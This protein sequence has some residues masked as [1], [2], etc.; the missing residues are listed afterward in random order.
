MTPD[1]YVDSDIILDLVIG[2]Q[3]F[4][5]EAKR[6]FAMAEYGKVKLHTT[7]VVFANIFY[8]LRKQYSAETIKTNLKILRQLIS[9]IPADESSVD[10]A[11]T[12]PFTDF[13]D[14]LQY[15]AALD[16]GMSAII[17]RNLS[18]FR[19]ATIPVMTAGEFLAQFNS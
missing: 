3:P 12:S 7:P 19:F 15:H 10:K 9:I 6:L 2:R 17:T 5:A 11:L 13:E 14:A 1:I 4:V 8:I 18:D 16:N